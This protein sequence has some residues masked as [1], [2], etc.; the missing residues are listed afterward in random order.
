MEVPS[1][2]SNGGGLALEKSSVETS[3]KKAM[4]YIRKVYSTNHKRPKMFE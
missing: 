1:L 3:R 2:S 4:T